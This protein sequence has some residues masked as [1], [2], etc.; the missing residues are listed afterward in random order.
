MV[1]VTFCS[2]LG[3]GDEMEISQITLMTPTEWRF[4]ITD[5]ERQEWRAIFVERNAY[6][7]TV[8]HK[9]ADNLNLYFANKAAGFPFDYNE[10]EHIADILKNGSE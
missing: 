3:S 8:M 7:A 2:R 4:L 10:K 9:M 6:P 5:G 1:A